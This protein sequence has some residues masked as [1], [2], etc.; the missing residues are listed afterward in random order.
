MWQTVVVDHTWLAS[1]TL[2]CTEGGQPAVKPERMTGKAW[3]VPVLYCTVTAKT[4]ELRC[5]EGGRVGAAT[6]AHE[7]KPNQ[8]RAK[9]RA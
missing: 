8:G 1:N 5:D 6:T 7:E 2:Y 4:L 9:R 3:L